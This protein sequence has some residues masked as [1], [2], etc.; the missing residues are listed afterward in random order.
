[1]YLHS[2][3]Q[4]QKVLD[5]AVTSGT[6]WLDIGCG[7]TLLPDWFRDSLQLQKELISRCD[8]VKGCDPVDARPH[9]A[10][11]EKYVGD[12]DV[13]PY[14]DN[15][16]TLV[17]AN[18]VVEH[19][20]DPRRFAGEVCRVLQPGG[21]FVAHTP[22]LRSPVV[23]P[24]RFLPNSLMRRIASRLDGRSAEDIFRTFYRMNTREALS[25]LPGFQV[26]EIRCEST[27]VFQKVPLLGWLE[28]K[29]IQHADRPWLRDRQ[30]DWIAVLRKQAV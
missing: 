14:P 23:Y 17:T 13:L 29:M 19:V 16:F 10:G 20:E 30:A 1:M 28:S 22:N 9:V 18:M 7:C 2:Q 4:Y 25:A 21:L 27:A 3:L 26:V 11:I 6:R 24:S 12:C 15:F 5:R 8:L